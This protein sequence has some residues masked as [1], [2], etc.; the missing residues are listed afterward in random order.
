M[1]RS[2]LREMAREGVK[3]VSD[4]GDLQRPRGEGKPGTSEELKYVH[5]G[6]NINNQ[7]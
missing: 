2:M 5:C 1:N 7:D 3:C 6:W 4:R